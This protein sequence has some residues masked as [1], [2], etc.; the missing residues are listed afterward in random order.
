[1]L[2]IICNNNNNVYVIYNNNMYVCMATIMYGQQ[3]II[4]ADG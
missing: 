3:L 1:M 4:M 2:A